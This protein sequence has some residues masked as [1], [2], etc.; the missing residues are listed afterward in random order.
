V[1]Y[2]VLADIHGNLAALECVV[3]RLSQARVDRYLVAG[4]LVGYGPWPNECVDAVRELDAVCVSGNHDLIAIGRLADTKCIRIARETLVWTRKVLRDD[5]SEYLA[6]LPTRAEIVGGVVIAHGSLDDPQEY[7]VRA[8]TAGVQLDRLAEDHPT[9][10]ILILGHT[11]RPLA[12]DQRLGRIRVAADST[13]RIG[14]GRCLL[15]PGAVGQSRELRARARYL[16]LDLE[17]RTATFHASVYDVAAARRAL[18][19][20]GLPPSTY[21]LRPSVTRAAMRRARSLP[22]R[23]THRA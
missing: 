18:R 20:A 1:R 7:V 12:F 14:D 16:V 8:E 2:A 21:H 19:R 15:N 22:G 9:G 10:S 11:H 13:I 3:E 23:L 4:D 17:E 5:V 6:T